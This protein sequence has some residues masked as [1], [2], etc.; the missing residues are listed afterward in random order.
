[1]SSSKK[2][3]DIIIDKIKLL[4][5]KKNS[6]NSLIEYDDVYKILLDNNEGIIPKNINDVNKLKEIN[7]TIK[8]LMSENINLVYKQIYK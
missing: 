3:K 7:E 8:A 1:M 4:I 6:E 2:P 5:N